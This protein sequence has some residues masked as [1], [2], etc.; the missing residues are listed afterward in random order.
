[1]QAANGQRL[2]V[3]KAHRR[4]NACSYL[5]ASRGA[6]ASRSYYVAR[7]RGGN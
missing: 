7:I 6:I 3:V 4:V 5:R 2:R 1:M